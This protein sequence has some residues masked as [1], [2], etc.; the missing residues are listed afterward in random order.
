MASDISGFYIDKLNKYRQKHQ[1]TITYKELRTTGPPHDKR[2]T[3]QVIINGKEFPEAEGKSKQDAKNAAAKLAVHM[4]T[5]ENKA[6]SHTDVSEE[7]SF[8]GNY[9]GLV[10]SFAQ[11]ERLP[12][13]YE[14]CDPDTQSP[15]RFKCK[16]KIGQTTYGI[17]LAATKQEAKQLAAKEAYQKLS[18]KSSVKTDRASS[19]FI[20]FSSSAFPSSLSVTNNSA[21]CSAPGSDFSE[22]AS[23]TS[24]SSQSSFVNGLRGN[25]RESEVKCTNDLLR[26]TCT[27]DYRFNKDFKDIEEI[28]SGGF[29]QVFKATHKIDK[30]T[31][32]IK[33]VRYNTEKAVREVT[34]LAALYHANIVQY[35]SCWMGEDYDPEQSVDKDTNRS[36]TQCLF[37]QMEFCDKGTL[38]QWM[39]E[40]RQSTADK[41]LVLEL[42]EQIVTGVDYIHSKSLIHRDLKPGNIFLVDEKHIKIGDFGLATAL[43]NDE[44]SRTKGTGTP[45]Y[46]SPEQLSSQEYGKEVDIFALGLILAEL[47]HIC[48]T[49][50]EKIKF[51]EKLRGGI[52]PDTFD[53]KE[54]SLLRILL[55]K[56]PTERPSTSEILRTLAEWKDI[57][58]KRQR[59]TC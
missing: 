12:V 25:Q 41:A 3:F 22:N 32:A 56:K 13:N 31:Y 30:K 23:E 9:I 26:N 29:G 7:G 14:Q 24:L 54:K 40:R 34:A 46:M 28:G 51:F 1:A 59:N 36:K 50:S 11:R 8:V 43:E 53:S 17:G 15:E 49:I 45:R 35:H 39:E 27:K 48:F 38:E 6:D 20:T 52:F 21:S 10:N 18:E 57:S 4:L 2:F 19:D 44:K 33:R 5:N 55:S 58:E 16:C 37:I 42:F 47:R